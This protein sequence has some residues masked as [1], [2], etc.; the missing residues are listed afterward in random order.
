[1]NLNKK[2]RLEVW[3]KYDFK[4]AYCG[5]DIEYKGMQ[6]NLLNP[7]FHVD[8]NVNN[9]RDFLKIRS[10]ENLMPSCIS[11][12]FFKRKDGLEKFRE[13][14]T[15]VH[16]R[17]ESDTLNKIA[18]T[19]N[20]IK[21]KPFSGKFYFERYR[22]T[23]GNIT[24]KN[25]LILLLQDFESNL[26]K[27]FNGDLSLSFLKYYKKFHSNKGS[28]KDVPKS[29]LLD[30]NTF[31]R[32]KKDLFDKLPIRQYPNTS[33]VKLSDKQLAELWLGRII[34]YFTERSDK[35]GL[36]YSLEDYQFAIAMIDKNMP[37]EVSVYNGKELKISYSL[38]FSD[39]NVAYERAVFY[40]AMYK[41]KWKSINNYI[42]IEQFGASNM[43]K[44]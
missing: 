18:I 33:L 41:H 25:Q 44:F 34:Q 27:C 2:T 22:Q 42:E 12:N 5:R 32:F 31:Y 36:L 15:N 16:K 9:K 11:C 38:C 40:I 23:Y 30:S 4:C 17:I 20:L 13:R 37:Y 8:F 39:V 1:M 19:F 6:I 10:M 14:M 28:K 35:Y 26:D 21:V 7:A 43:L 24:D 3:A 29:M